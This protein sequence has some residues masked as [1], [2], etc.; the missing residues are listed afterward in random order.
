MRLEKRWKLSADLRSQDEL[1]YYRSWGPQAIHMLCQIP[2]YN[3]AVKIAA[4]LKLDE[5]EVET[6]LSQM[7]S[8]GLLTSRN[9]NY[10]CVRESIHLPKE[11]PSVARFHSNWRI[12]AI[13]QLNE[14]EP[15]PCTHYSAVV[16]LSAKSAEKIRRIILKHL[17]ES[18]RLIENSESEEV[19]VHIIDFFPLMASKKRPPTG[20]A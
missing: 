15:I 17:E 16:A 8:M 14:F 1:M 7:E 3:T 18:R 12:K 10:R 19:W 4:T 5:S 2:G 6:A 13:S 20:S 11:S 9:G